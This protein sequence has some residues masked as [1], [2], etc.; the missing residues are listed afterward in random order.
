M[1]LKMP[2]KLRNFTASTMASGG[3]KSGRQG[4]GQDVEGG[5]CAKEHILF[6]VKTYK[7]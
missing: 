6:Q 1:S 5:W 4:Q 2:G 7:M 3:A